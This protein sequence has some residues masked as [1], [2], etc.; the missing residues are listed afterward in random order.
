LYLPSSVLVTGYDIIF[1][2]VARM[3][4]AGLEFTGQSPFREVYIHGLVRDKQGRK[5]SKSLGNGLDPLEI[6]DEYGADALKFTLAYNCAAGQ[7]ILVDRE[8]FKMGSKFA[9]KIWNASRYILM[10]LEGRELVDAASLTYNDLDAWILHS[11]NEAAG[12][13]RASLESWRF[14]EA[15]QA[16][17]AF[18]WDDFCDWYIEATK[19]SLK[20]EDEA[21]KNRATT[22]LLDVLEESLRL[23][24]PLLPFVTEEIY[25]ML[26]N[27]SGSLI[28]AA[29]PECVESRRSPG[30]AAEFSRCSIHLSAS[31]RTGASTSSR[32]SKFIRM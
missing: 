9:N 13:V 21:E 27:A 18:F 16:A 8:S 24:H 5:M 3:I 17:Y 28:M 23:L 7:D 6:V 22:V 26:P 29:Y 31:M 4:M 12:Q 25:G 10:N 2:W 1:F 14:N 20:G 15:A 30:I 11:L 32:P 19:L